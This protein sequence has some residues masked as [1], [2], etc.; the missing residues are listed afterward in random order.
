MVRRRRWSWSCWSGHKGCW[1]NIW[2]IG[3]VGFLI[4]LNKPK[5]V[6]SVEFSPARS[7]LVQLGQMWFSS[8]KFGSA[9]SNVVQL[10]QMWFSSVKS[11][12][13]RSKVVQLGQIWSSSVRNG[14]GRS[15]VLQVGQKWSGRSKMVNRT[16]LTQ[17]SCSRLPI[18]RPHSPKRKRGRM[19]S[20]FLAEIL[21]K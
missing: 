2:Q 1:A 14:P 13:A 8:V 4:I 21:Q 6:S 17:I 5:M 16:Y 3:P 10:G 20:Q 7:N 15:N 9:R 19:K 18:N 11:G 12:P